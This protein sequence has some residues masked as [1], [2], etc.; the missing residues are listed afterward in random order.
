[1][2]NKNQLRTTLEEMFKTLSDL[3]EIQGGTV[4]RMSR[5]QRDIKDL[6]QRCF[7]EKVKVDNLKKSVR[8]MLDIDMDGPAPIEV[9][10][11]DP[12]PP[13]RQPQ[14]QQKLPQQQPQPQ[15]TRKPEPQPQP[16][17]QT[18]PRPQQKLPQQQ[19]QPEPKQKP[20]PQ[21]QRSDNNVEETEASP[22]KKRRI[23]DTQWQ[24]QPSRAHVQEP[25][26]K[27]AS[28]TISDT[29]IEE[30]SQPLTQ[31]QPPTQ[32]FEESQP[33]HKLNSI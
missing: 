20:E 25:W 15:P 21:P 8:M 18:Q 16:R 3:S 30:D 12:G 11:A 9:Q 24:P 2:K 31:T 4:E 33:I 26:V 1:M 6:G 32:F 27:V 19:P 5:L 28:T 14:P 29:Q 7:Y 10:D 13:Q 17:P 22:S 23:N